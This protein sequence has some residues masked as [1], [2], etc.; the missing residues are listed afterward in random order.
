MGRYL[1]ER[2]L[3]DISKRLRRAREQL[4]VTEQQ[5][6][7]LSET[8]DEARV[9]SLVAESPLATKQYREAQRSADA[10]GSA[11]DNLAGQVHRLEAEMD[12]LLDRL[13]P[14]S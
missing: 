4:S 9:R 1:V 11:R 14:G 13:V 12:E 8:A 3:T 10:M 6:A 2:K 5:L 7:A